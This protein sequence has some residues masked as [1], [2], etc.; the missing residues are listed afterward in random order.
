MKARNGAALAGIL[1]LLSLLGWSFVKVIWIPL[2]GGS[3]SQAPTSWPEEP[4]RAEIVKE[5]GTVRSWPVADAQA[6]R[7]LR[8]E[9]RRADTTTSNPPPRQDQN[10]RLR[11]RRP[12]SRVDDYEVLLDERGNEPDLL[13]VI[14]RPGGASIYGSALKTPEL[15]A[16]LQQVLKEPQN[17]PK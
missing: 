17:A 15:R 3:G 13:Y 8:E 14:R 9:L 12:D 7:K 5:D 11:I 6:L 4:L 2:Y 10:Y 16:A 1:A